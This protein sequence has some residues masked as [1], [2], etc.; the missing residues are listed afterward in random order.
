MILRIFILGILFLKATLLFSQDYIT[1]NGTISNKEETTKKSKLVDKL[2][3]G[4]NFML[5]PYSE[6][7]YNV[8]YVDMSPM[9]GYLLTDRLI[10]GNYFIFKY[11]GNDYYKFY[12][13]IYGLKPYVRY[14]LIKNIDNI[15][16]F[17]SNINTGISLVASQDFLNV[18]KRI[19]YEGKGRE[20]ITGTFGG[21]SI[22]Q[23][24][25]SK[26]GLYFSILWLIA[27]SNKTL[28]LNNYYS[29]IL[30]LGFYL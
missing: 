13:S 15:L 18:E 12:T 9:V 27:G 22:V 7:G 26:G 24:L 10:T 14:K 11:Y 4:G 3:F 17:D 8:F 16:P 1:E 20:W 19:F 30:E 21:I 2:I 29:P 23:P 6:Y 28:F 5:E 25:G